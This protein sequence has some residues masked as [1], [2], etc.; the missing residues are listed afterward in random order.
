MELGA[1]RSDRWAIILAGG[2]GMRLRPLTRRIAG[3]ERPKQFCPFVGGET[4]LDRTRAR[5]ARSVR[6]DR[7]CLVLTRSHETFYAPL[8]AEGPPGPL[9]VQPCGRGT[10]PAILYGLLRVAESGILGRGRPVPLGPLRVGR[11]ALHGARGGGLCR[12]RGP[13]RPGRSPGDRGG[14]PRGAV[15]LD[16]G[17]GPGRSTGRVSRLPGP[18]ILGEARRRRWRR[19]SSSADASGTASCWWRGCRRCSP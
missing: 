11:C 1:R 3:D 8:L 15:R 17:G 18:A 2:E 14:G 13:S 5:V 19:R 7:T 10:A 12:G 6:P 16:R 4:L 9:V